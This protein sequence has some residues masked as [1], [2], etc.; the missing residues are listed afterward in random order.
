MCNEIRSTRNLSSSVRSIDIKDKLKNTF[1]ENIVF[2]K[3]IGGKTNTEYV[4][5]KESDKIIDFA[6]IQL[7][8]TLPNSLTF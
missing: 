8:S 2:K 7:V 5:S 4:M 3:M 1:N 6:N